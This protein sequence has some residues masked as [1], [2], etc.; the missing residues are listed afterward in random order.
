MD[1]RTTFR[2]CEFP[3]NES[4][5]CKPLLISRENLRGRNHAIIIEKWVAPLIGHLYLMRRFLAH[6][7]FS[8][9][10]ESGKTFRLLENTAR[11]ML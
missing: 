6:P 9:R 5:E 4:T 1:G 3:E 2:T 10:T 7:V 8:I 11:T